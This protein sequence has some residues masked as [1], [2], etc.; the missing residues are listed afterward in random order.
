MYWRPWSRARD[1]EQRVAVGREARAVAGERALYDDR[2]EVDV[3]GCGRAEALDRSDRTA[4]A[5]RDTA[6]PRTAPL[7]GQHR[8]EEHREHAP[9][10]PVVVRERVAQPV[11]R[12]EYPLADRETTEH[13][14]HQVCCQASHAP[15]GARRADAAS[16]A[17]ERDQQIL[18]AR[19]A[20]E[21]GEAARQL[22]AGQELAQLALDEVRQAVAV[23]AG[24]RMGEKGL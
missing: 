18:L 20:A 19:V 17:G 23:A 8:T 2:V 4:A 21:A 9:A 6:P 22:A 1:R 24:T 14:V 7:G 13:V 15:P 16:L 5:V 10:E 3:D 11:R 12:G